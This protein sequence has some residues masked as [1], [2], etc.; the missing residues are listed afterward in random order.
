MREPQ[1][2]VL[3]IFLSKRQSRFLKMTQAQ[4]TLK[5]VFY[6]RHVSKDLPR[7]FEK[8]KKEA[9]K[10]PATYE[11]F[12]TTKICPITRSKYMIQIISE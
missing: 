11:C 7:N 4:A 3:S 12:H 9:A 1:R 5:N 6:E 8:L 2:L 10:E